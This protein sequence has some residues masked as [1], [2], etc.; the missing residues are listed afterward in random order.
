M[1]SSDRPNTPARSEFSVP[2]SFTSYPHNKMNHAL[3]EQI[4]A[5]TANDMES[6]Q[7]TADPQSIRDTSGDSE[8]INN[9]TP[10]DFKKTIE[11]LLQKISNTDSHWTALQMR[12]STLR[13]EVDALI[14]SSQ[15]SVT[16][17]QTQT[18][19]QDV[20]NA[21]MNGKEPEALETA[22]GTE[23]M[24]TVKLPG[25]KVATQIPHE[26]VLKGHST[27][28]ES[29]QSGDTMRE[30]DAIHDGIQIELARYKKLINKL[31]QPSTM[32][33]SNQTQRSIEDAANLPH[34]AVLE[35]FSHT[36]PV[37]IADARKGCKCSM[38]QA[39]VSL[40]YLST[41]MNPTD[42]FCSYPTTISGMEL[43]GL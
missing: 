23:P 5:S 26:A 11:G 17:S 25:S 28:Q 3:D 4:S 29:I 9:M 27:V 39:V 8:T 40:F 6:L 14:T 19:E 43:H 36:C 41:G 34:N 16:T 18:D 24:I 12:A 35:L 38:R 30:V 42:Y 21:V 7:H 10:G 37:S 13:S 32:L 22:V 31:L 1:H 2:P 33:E 20:C 15:T